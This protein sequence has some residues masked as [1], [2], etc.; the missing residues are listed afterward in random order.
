MP[1]ADNTGAS[2]TQQGGVPV[3]GGVARPAGS[4]LPAAAAACAQCV[5]DGVAWHEPDSD[6]AGA[7]HERRAPKPDATTPTMHQWVPVRN[8]ARANAA[9]A[10]R[11]RPFPIRI[12]T[13]RSIGSA[14]RRIVCE[15]STLQRRNRLWDMQQ[16][17]GKAE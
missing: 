13:I 6:R 15:W 12:M 10:P 14:A 4:V 8:S 2:A 1:G 11:G 3:W 16:R 7:M 17:H 9:I 5:E